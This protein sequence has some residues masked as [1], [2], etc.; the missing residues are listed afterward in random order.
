MENLTGQ[1]LCFVVLISKTLTKVT[2]SVPK[3][4][5]QDA[6]KANVKQPKIGVQLFRSWQMVTEN[7][8]SVQTWRTAMSACRDEDNDQ[9]TAPEDTTSLTLAK[10]Q[11]AGLR[12]RPNNTDV[13]LKHSFFCLQTLGQTHPLIWSV[14]FILMR[15]HSSYKG[16]GSKS[17]TRWRCSHADWWLMGFCFVGIKDWVYGSLQSSERASVEFIWIIHRV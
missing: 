16:H 12:I 5:Y 15:C 2:R 3:G 14:S 4:L 13:S 17:F 1:Y 9:S 10:P 8:W 6:K 7:V 11:S